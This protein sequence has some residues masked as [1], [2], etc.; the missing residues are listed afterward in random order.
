[1]R[2]SC[3]WSGVKRGTLEQEGATDLRG[4]PL[5]GPSLASLALSLAALRADCSAWNARSCSFSAAFLCSTHHTTC[6]ISIVTLALNRSTCRP[7][8]IE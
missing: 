1:M 2:W 5:G 3:F 7:L 8:S 4:T 6:Q